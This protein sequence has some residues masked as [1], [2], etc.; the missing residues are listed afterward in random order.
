MSVICLVEAM[1]DAPF[2]YT[3]SDGKIQFLLWIL[4]GVLLGC[5]LS[6]MLF[7]IIVDPFLCKPDAEVCLAGLGTVRACADD[8]GATL[9][10]LSGLRIAKRTI[11]AANVQQ[12]CA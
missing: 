10:D 1:Y 12:T 2:A 3:V 11:D 7:V 5:P 6:G 9:K 4:A 8:V